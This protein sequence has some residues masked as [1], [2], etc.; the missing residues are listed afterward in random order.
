MNS[1]YDD[2][3]QKGALLLLLS[4]LSL[5]I[6]LPSCLLLFPNLSFLPAPLHE[7][8]L[9]FKHSKILPLP[10]SLPWPLQWRCD[11]FLIST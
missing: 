1:Y 11:H 2:L 7:A 9:I 4:K 8:R 5:M 6:L 3:T 10:G